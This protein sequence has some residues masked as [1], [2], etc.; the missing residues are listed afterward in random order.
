MAFGDTAARLSPYMQ[1]ALDNRDVRTQLRRGTDRVRDAY[2]RGRKRRVKA[3][4]DEKL[5]RQ[6]REGLVAFATAAAMLKKQTEKP[7]RHRGR[8]VLVVLSL[9]A[10]GT[11]AA[12]VLKEQG[13][14][15]PDGGEQR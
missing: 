2:E 7:K 8:R 14:D 9:G 13:R 5:R 11:G 10:I 3:A 6:A 4:R 1:E 15:E 12:Y